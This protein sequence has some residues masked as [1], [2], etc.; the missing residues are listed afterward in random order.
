MALLAR[1]FPGLVLVSLLLAGCSGA[2]GDIKQET[3][4]GG[5]PLAGQ[6]INDQQNPI[7]NATVLLTGKKDAA[8]VAR[9]QTDEQGLFR[10]GKVPY[11][12][13]V[14]AVQANGYAAPVPRNILLVRGAESD[15]TH[16]KITLSP[17]PVIE[18]YH[19]TEPKTLTIQIGFAYQVNGDFNQGCISPSVTCNAYAYPLPNAYFRSEDPAKTP[20]RAAVIE[21]SWTST[22]ALC[23][24]T[25]AVDVYNP[26]APSTQDPTRGNPHY[27]TN[28]PSEKW[29]TTSPIV[30]VIPRNETGNADAVNHPERMAKNGGEMLVRGNWT[31]RNFPPGKGLTNLPV[32]ANCFT[33]QKF[34]IFWTTFYLDAPP[35]GFTARNV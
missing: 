1:S 17:V 15:M 8:L 34:D 32:D 10:L 16:L 11:G 30:M 29:K 25:L 28:Y 22:S 5:Q 24:K 21:E 33:D 20:W 12:E 19:I 3:S 13:F 9:A 23:A 18:P 7:A 27:W 26:D 4:P 2:K 31:V 6:V 14:L 35:L